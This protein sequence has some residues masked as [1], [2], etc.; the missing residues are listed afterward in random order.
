MPVRRLRRLQT[1]VCSQLD[2]GAKAM[3]LRARAYDRADNLDSARILYEAAARAAPDVKTGSISALRAL[4]ATKLR[5]IVF[6]RVWTCRLLQR[7]K[8]QQR[9]SRSSE[10][11]T[12]PERSRLTPQW[13][14]D[15]RRSGSGCCARKTLRR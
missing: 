4:R 14:T 11:A 8:N 1:F 2:S 10:P 13:E 6:L 3:V 9:Q 5:A 15:L 7:G 12:C